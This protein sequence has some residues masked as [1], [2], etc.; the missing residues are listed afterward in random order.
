[1]QHVQQIELN[2]NRQ[3]K[4][5]SKPNQAVIIFI[6]FGQKLNSKDFKVNYNIIL[7]QLEVKIK[8]QLP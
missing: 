6:F 2:T 1:M 3:G 8:I 4:T 5:K 7:N